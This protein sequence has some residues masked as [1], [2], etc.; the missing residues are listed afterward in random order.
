MIIDFHTHMFPDKI[1]SATIDYLADIC[2]IAPHTNGT[3]EGLKAE[4][5]SS[6]VDLS[7]ALPIVTKPKQ[8]DS[9]NR[10]ASNYQS[11]NV[12]SFGSI[13]PDNDGYKEKLRQIKEMGLKGIKLHPDYQEV[14]FNDIRYKRIVSYASEL[15][16]IVV[17]HAGKDP[18]SPDDIHC[19]PQ[20]S[21][22]LL[23]EVQPEKLVLAHMGGNLQWT[24]VEEYLVGEQVYFDTGVVLDQI[25]QEQFLRMVRNHGAEKILFA[26]DSPWAGQKE[27]I[28]LLEQMPLTLDEKE[29]IFSKNA[30]KLLDF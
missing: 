10:F 2:Q 16:L 1:A 18:K 27:Y 3:Y 13:H 30:L 9:I 20:M 5:E 15:G 22:E 11:G 21:A 25:S 7:V 24:E 14:Y 29:K 28:Q 17:V 12:L 6:Q 19:T 23:R 26:T 8:F 4:T